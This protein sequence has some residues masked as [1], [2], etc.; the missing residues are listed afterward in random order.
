MKK[1]LHPLDRAIRGVVGIVFTGFALFYG[2]Y[3][4]EPVLEVLIGVF[5]VLNLISL[6]FGW[7]PVYHFSGISTC[8]NKQ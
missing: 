3:L 5:G 1:N 8:K 4:D 2:D 6:L 7:C